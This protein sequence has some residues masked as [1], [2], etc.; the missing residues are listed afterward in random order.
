MAEA[1]SYILPFLFNIDDLQKV[2]PKL[3]HKFR[4]LYNEVSEQKDTQVAIKI[5]HKLRHLYDALGQGSDAS[6]T[7]PSMPTAGPS[8]QSVPTTTGITGDRGG[9]DPGSTSRITSASVQDRDPPGDVASLHVVE[10]AATMA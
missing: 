6:G 1:V 3:Q 9:P 10:Q 5:H 8:G 4:A 7:E 2:E